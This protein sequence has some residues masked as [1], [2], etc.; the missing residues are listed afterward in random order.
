M[1]YLLSLPPNLA[2]SFH[3][4]ENRPPEDWF[5]T[6]DP[7]QAKLGSGGGTAFL[8]EAAW[9][10]SGTSGSFEQWLGQEKKILMHAGGQSRRL[11]AYA[12]S[13]KILTPI[14]VFRW[15]RGQ[16]LN[17]HLLDLQLPLLEEIMAEAPD[18]YHTLV[19]CGDTLIR[20][21]GELPPMPAVDILCM[22]IWVKP[23]LGGR[24]GT[25]FMHRRNPEQLAF[26]L[27][28][29]SPAQLAELMVDYN[30][31]IDVGI[32]LLSDRAV[33]VLMKKSRWDQARQAFGQEGVPG[34]YDL[35]TDFGMSIGSHPTE[36]D[37][38]IQSLTAAAIPL[39]QGEFYHFGRSVEIISS[40]LQLQN[41]V[42]DQRTIFHR[43]IKGHSNIFIMNAPAHLPK[44]EAQPEVWIENSHLSPAWQLA[45]RHI[46]TGIPKNDWQ[47]DIPEGVCLDIIP[48]GS[49]QYCV[50][51]YGID[52]VFKGP[53]GQEK[54]VWMGQPLQSWLSA[55]EISWEEA[56][57]SPET[58]L[59]QAALF[60]VLSQDQLSGPL[61]QWMMTAPATP[62]PT[63]KE[64]WLKAR[65][66]AEEISTQANLVRLYEQRKAFRQASLPTLA[67]NASRSIF[68]Q[69]DLAHLA[70]D[71]AAT[72]L[73]L[74]AP[75]E[76]REVPGL[77]S[78]HDAMFRSEVFRLKG[79]MDKSQELE[80]QAFQR[81][82]D[83][84][85][86]LAKE[87]P[88]FP[89]RNTLADQIVWARAPL[90]FDL[91]GGWS[92]T[93]PYCLSYG[94]RVVNMAVELNGQPPIQVYIKPIDR[95]EIIIRSIDQSFEEKLTEFADLANYN[96]LGS[97]FAIPK[98][99]LALAGFLP[100]F[101]AHPQS[102]LARQLAEAG[103]GLELSLLAAVPKGSGLGTSSILAATVLGALN[104]F[105][106]LGWDQLEIGNRTLMLE[107]LLTSGGGWQD[108][109][110]GIL[111]GIKY[112]ETKA[113]LSQIPVVR[114]LPAM[115]LN[116]PEQKDS[117][118]LYYTGITRVAHNILGEIVKGMFLN[119]AQHLRHVHRQ[120]YHGQRTYEVLQKGNYEETARMIQLTWQINQALDS[121]T[122]PP[123][124]Q[125]IIAQVQDYLAGVKLLGAGGGGFL[126]FMAKDPFAALSI[127]RSLEQNPPNA[128]ARFV[129][130]DIS[131]HGLQVTRS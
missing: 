95:P 7:P 9:K 37:E 59:Q 33:E 20:A 125:A 38:E 1:K 56:G 129:S 104:D 77:R 89:Q 74:P 35:Y 79:V 67:Q 97:A 25:F 107:Q 70:R 29:P 63:L 42:T 118:L 69:L 24:H 115:F 66:S 26:G 28:K 44:G 43:K 62:N 30:F 106:Q 120:Y 47:M 105:F 101:S 14:P 111:P 5:C 98:A 61:V 100:T 4:I 17:Q 39:P 85:L 90:R 32:W 123:A 6:S 130:F 64:L 65:L 54:T 36:I 34:Y 96:Q 131:Q 58:D 13:G 12:P 73:E 41:L 46:L 49:S 48:I 71:Y 108:Q 86:S 55:R 60:P 91:A 53:I 84:I 81:L 88:V 3:Q 83:R 103:G 121:G 27:Q 23:E 122:N 22:G 78:I 50:R 94:G 109:Y 116:Q 102:S 45:G 15:A 11:P 31:M 52:D 126:L 75:V 93:P 127:K 92:D 124:V 72:G 40:S 112:L 76:V 114:W 117:M 128:L 80:S 21:T 18:S 19:A 51:P 113:G 2:Q 68:Y 82:S 57:L 87:K 110:G 16:Q 10:A 99:A 119:S 8:L